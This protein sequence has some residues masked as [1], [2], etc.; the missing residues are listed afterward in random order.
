MSRFFFC[1][2]LPYPRTRR[3]EANA[4][5]MIYK[6]VTTPQDKNIYAEAGTGSFCPPGTCL[7]LMI[8]LGSLN[9]SPAHND[10]G[11]PCRYICVGLRFGMLCPAG[12]LQQGA[13]RQI[14]NRKSP[15]GAYRRTVGIYALNPAGP[16]FDREGTRILLCRAGTYAETGDGAGRT[17]SRRR[18]VRNPHVYII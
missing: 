18:P 4:E 14:F 11:T 13:D 17:G 10:R 6:R 7:F 1:I 3:Q 9:P 12:S 2:F 8:C 15:S 5:K 16:E